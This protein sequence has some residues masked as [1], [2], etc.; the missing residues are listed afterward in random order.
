[1]NDHDRAMVGIRAKTDW[2]GG[3]FPGLRG[4]VKNTRQRLRVDEGEDRVVHVMSRLVEGVQWWD[5]VEKEALAV[6]LERM[7]SFCGIEMLTWCVMGNHFHA[8]VREPVRE[9]WMARFGGERGEEHLW[10]HLG[11]L[12]TPA[13]VKGLRRDVAWLRE[14]G[15]GVEAEEMI[16]GYKRRLCDV[17]LWMKEVKE[18]FAKW[19][20]KRRGRRGTVWMER[21]KSVLVQTGEALRTMSLYIDLNPVRAGIVENA[22]D[23]RWSAYGMAVA[24]DHASRAAICKVVGLGMAGEAKRWQEDAAGIYAMWLADAVGETLGEDGRC[25]RR[26]RIAG[27]VAKS[28]DAIGG[29]PELG[30]AL[31]RRWRDF[32]EGVALGGREWVE[33]I[34][35]RNR[36]GFGEKR[37]NGARKP[38]GVSTE[39]RV[40]RYLRPDNRRTSEEKSRET[41]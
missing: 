40:L 8:L 32:S 30:R 9:K 12:Y 1:M 15:R 37:K 2:P 31:G 28:A 36:E 16:G 35:A 38:P 13:Y 26:E 33:E 18:R 6:L 29:R 20:N 27:S 41:P 4:R 10:E 19:L 39:L 34:F 14:R 3:E 24:G 7:A 11:T 5:E 17:S 23:Y 22:A 25:S 21:Y